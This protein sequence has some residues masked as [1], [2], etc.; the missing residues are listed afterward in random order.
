[1]SKESWRPV[2]SHSSWAW[3]HMATSVFVGL[4]GLVM[5]WSQVFYMMKHGLHGFVLFTALLALAFVLLVCRSSVAGLSSGP[6][7]LRR[8]SLTK[9]RYF[10][11]NEIASFELRPR[12]WRGMS[13]SGITF[14]T[15][16][17][18]AINTEVIIGPNGRQPSVGLYSAE[19]VDDLLA[20]LEAQR[21][22]ETK[23]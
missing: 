21:A 12:K 13:V 7:G 18:E 10:A 15:T 23:S 3:V 8:R 17:G 16:A 22:V 6:A 11:W 4:F 9:T 2:T 1:M 14:V 5:L 19:E 20:E